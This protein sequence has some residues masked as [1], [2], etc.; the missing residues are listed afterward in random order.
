MAALL[1]PMSCW[2]S[3]AVMKTRE[4]V[5][6]PREYHYLWYYLIEGTVTKYMTPN[7]CTFS[8]QPSPS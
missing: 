6:L 3:G 8:K 4:A 1:V 5:H 2:Q 7:Y